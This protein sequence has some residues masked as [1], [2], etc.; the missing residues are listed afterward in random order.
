MRKKLIVSTGDKGGVGKSTA[1]IA[2]IEGAHSLGLRTFL[3]EGDPSIPDV[4]NRYQG[5]IPGVQVS[6]ARPD[7]AGDAL[8]ELMNHLEQRTEEADV[9][10]LNLPAGAAS[11]IDQQAEELILPCLEAFELDLC[12]YWPGH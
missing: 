9:L 5:W 8:V 1:L 7:S 6:L 12:A 4:Q 3:I 2:V 11:T 10:M